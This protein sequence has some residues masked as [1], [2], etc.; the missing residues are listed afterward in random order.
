MKKF[1]GVFTL[2]SVFS[3][4]SGVDSSCLRTIEKITASPEPMRAWT[5][6]DVLFKDSTEIEKVF[7]FKR[8]SNGKVH[9]R[10]KG[11]NKQIE[12]AEFADWRRSSFSIPDLN[13]IPPLMRGLVDVHK[14]AEMTFSPYQK[15]FKSNNFEVVGGAF[16]DEQ[17]AIQVGKNLEEFDDKMTLLG[18]KLPHK[19]RV[20][21]GEDPILPS[22]STPHATTAKVFNLWSFDSKKIIAMYPDF[23]NSQIVSDES[24]LFHE[25]M[26]NLLY[27]TYSS[28]AFVNN[29][30]ITQEA[31]ADSIAALTID[32]PYLGSS[33]NYGEA[34]LRNLKDRIAIVD[35]TKSTR[36]RLMDIRPK[37]YHNN[38]MMMS[39]AIWMIRQ[40]IGLEQ[41]LVIFKQFVDNLNLYRSSFKDFIGK[42]PQDIKSKQK[43]IFDIEYF[44]SVL[45]KTLED[46]GYSKENRKAVLKVANSYGIPNHR[47]LKIS[48]T[49]MKSNNSY[50]NQK[51]D[52]NNQTDLSYLA[53]GILGLVAEGYIIY[54]A[55]DNLDL[56]PDR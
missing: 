23:Y 25:R 49:L 40:E 22:L 13:P 8:L 6:Y 37:D 28:D 20:I 18:F 33:V 10:H 52:I 16:A 19:T 11:K 35:N 44:L 32:S 38:S 9:I 47:I 48:N 55:T 54:E 12:I 50:L 39:H 26:H 21:V 29:S 1:I 4:A 31:L 36:N 17:I 14:S 42:K 53:Y 56:F 5:F 7:F 3:L 41:T 51:H 30:S 24:I 43:V 46:E 2:L 34:P 27:S 45:A 15:F